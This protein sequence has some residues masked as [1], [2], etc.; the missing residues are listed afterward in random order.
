MALWT[1]SELLTALDSQIRSEHSKELTKNL[2]IKTV[3]N[4]VLIDSRKTSNSG[5]FIALKGEKNDG[6]NFINQAFE[7]KAS[8][9]IVERIPDNIS[10][11]IHSQ[12]I[13]V[14]DSF[15]ALNDLA[16]F[17][18]KRSEAKIIAIT[19]SVGKTS[20]KEMLKIAFESQGKT[21]ASL[22]NFNNHFGL[23][24]SLANMESDCDFAIFEIGMNHHHEIEPLVKL[25]EPNFAAITNVGPVHIEFFKDEQDIALAKSEIFSGFK[26][27]G[28]VA[29]NHDNP[30]FDFLLTQAKIHGIEE[31]NIISF[32]KSES[33]R[34]STSYQLTSHEI[35]SQ[36]LSKV[37]IKHNNKEEFGYKVGCISPA[38]A[39][40]SLIVA[41]ALD[42]FGCNVQVG[43]NS[44]E[45]YHQTSG[46]GAPISVCFQ[47]K[48][49]LIIDDS[50]NAS[51]VSVKSGLEYAEKLFQTSNQKRLLFALGD[52]L[53]LGQSSLQIH[54]QAVSQALSKN[55]DILILVG[56][57]MSRAVEAIS[58]SADFNKSKI[59][60]I[61]LFDD[62]KLAAEKIEELILDG[63]L[64]YVKGSRGTKME[65]IIQQISK[66]TC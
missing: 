18:R 11:E 19:G 51:I 10:R 39:F 1:I 50:Y 24:L 61:R 36:S 66:K 53:E 17:S 15:C 55:F 65:R 52:M 4:E 44:L 3:V 46:R 49:L 12:L 21:F 60:K 32:G 59:T 41:C 48:N 9:A 54:E 2:N 5:L 64:I 13:V 30:H 62:S 35:L 40:N 38:H 58:Q 26:Q 37:S 34:L 8:I 7:N 27:K 29:I 22:G 33:K 45:N 31:K 25:L 23:P 20:T 28:I 42:K 47:N 63:D 14:K 56:K 57:E 16:R 6:H 43:L